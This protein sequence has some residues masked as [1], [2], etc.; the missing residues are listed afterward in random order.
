[1]KQNFITSIS[2]CT[3]VLVMLFSCTKIDF[4]LVLPAETQTGANTFG[5]LVNGE[6]WRVKTDKEK[7]KGF[8]EGVTAFIQDSV[9]HIQAVDNGTD[10]IANYL[11]VIFVNLKSPARPFSTIDT[12][13]YLDLH[14]YAHGDKSAWYRSCRDCFSCTT[15]TGYPGPDQKDSGIITITRLDDKIV[16]GRFEGKL[17]NYLGGSAILTEGRFD[18]KLK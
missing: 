3:I 15:C 6:V 18:I 11:I 5:C 17:L 1:M 10:D 14:D 12:I 2:Q 9:L 8:E 7:R 4:P 13:N 16:S